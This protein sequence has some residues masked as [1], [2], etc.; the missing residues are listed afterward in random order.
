M[1]RVLERLKKF[2]VLACYRISFMILTW[3][4]LITV[5]HRLS[6]LF[7]GLAVTEGLLHNSKHNYKTMVLKISKVKTPFAALK[8]DHQFAF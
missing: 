4:W 1:S 8:I 7:V 2:P 6:Q 5:C 3:A